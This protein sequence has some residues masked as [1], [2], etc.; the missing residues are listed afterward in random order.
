M[1]FNY[2]FY[3]KYFF[4]S[5]MS[6]KFISLLIYNRCIH[7]SN[8]RLYL[9]LIIKG[10]ANVSVQL[11]AGKCISIRIRMFHAIRAKPSLFYNTL[12]SFSGRF[13]SHDLLT[14]GDRP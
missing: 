11:V 10:T 7:T 14:V 9:R 5:V 12:L 2:V 3:I 8:Y 13:L 4:A 6:V 1:D